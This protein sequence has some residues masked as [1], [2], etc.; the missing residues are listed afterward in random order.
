[1]LNSVAVGRR[2]ALR[3]AA[4]QLLAVGLVAALFLLRG[5]PQALAAALGGLAMLA[6]GLAAARLALGGGVIPAGAAMLRLLAGMILKWAV[7]FAV[8][9]VG[10]GAWKLPPLPLMTGLLTGLAAQ[11]LAAARRQ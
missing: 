10:L 8:L 2:L 1:M 4:Y 5:L 9:L 3:A 6:G 11:V 7:V